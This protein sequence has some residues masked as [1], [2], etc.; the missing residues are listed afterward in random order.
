MTR[1][2]GWRFLSIGPPR[3]AAADHVQ[4]AAGARPA[5]AAPTGST[6]CSSSPTRASPTARATWP[7]PSGCR[8]STCSCATTPTRA[9]SRS[10]PRDSP[11]SSPRS[12]RPTAGSPAAILAP[13]HAA[14]GALRA[15]RPHA[16]KRCARR[17][18]RRS[19]SRRRSRSRTR[20]RSSSSRTPSRAACSSSSHELDGRRCRPGFR[21]LHGRARDAL[22]L[23][24]PGG[25][26]LAAR[27]P[28]AAGAALA[29]GCS[30]HELAIEPPPDE[31]HE[32]VRLLRQ[33]RDPL[34]HA[35]RRIRCCA[36]A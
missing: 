14:L 21:P 28:D 9:R 17:L 30:S 11:N 34:P 22:R 36:C 12:R 2:I 26:V 18:R 33:R 29:E 24:R 16:G 8:C 1:G 27:P 10:R 25:A 6:G 3:R 23:P 32:R 13:A 31:R 4:R 19:C 35:R 15:R 7:R 20:S 5:R